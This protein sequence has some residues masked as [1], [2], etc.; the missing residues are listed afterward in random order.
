MKAASAFLILAAFP[1]H[2]A[3]ATPPAPP[4]SLSEVPV[5]TTIPR[6]ADHPK[7]TPVAAM[8]L[9]QKNAHKAAVG[10]YASALEPVAEALRGNTAYV[11]NFIKLQQARRAAGVNVLIGIK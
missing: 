11:I 5:R 4:E 9:S 8:S 10:K 7:A 2:S 1:L 3:L 6:L